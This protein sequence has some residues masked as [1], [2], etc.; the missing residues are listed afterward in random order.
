M[1]YES[2]FISKKNENYTNK[3]TILL[4]LGQMI[5]TLRATSS[6]LH[7]SYC[8]ENNPCWFICQQLYKPQQKHVIQKP[9]N[10]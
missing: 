10:Y 7:A 8:S 6:R 3:R 2:G 5:E 1:V 4:A 9:K